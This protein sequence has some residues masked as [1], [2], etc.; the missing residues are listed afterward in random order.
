MVNLQN[1]ILLLLYIEAFCRSFFSEPLR[2]NELHGVSFSGNP[3]QNLA[4]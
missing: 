1:F 2:F 4:E 3:Q